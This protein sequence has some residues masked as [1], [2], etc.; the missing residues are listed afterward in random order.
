M[1]LEMGNFHVKD[2]VFGD[3]LSY[4]NG[5][6]TVNKEELLNYVKEEE[7]GITTADLRIVRPGIKSG[8]AR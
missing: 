5:V 8:S 3:T 6:L 4:S 2:I 1:R 7:P